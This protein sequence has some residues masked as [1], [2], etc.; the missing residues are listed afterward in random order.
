MQAAGRAAQEF[1]A[2][3]MIVKKTSAEYAHVLD[4]PPCPS[5]MVNNRFIAKND[6]VTYEALAEAITDKS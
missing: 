6:I 4:S 2:E 3:I 1:G 5:V